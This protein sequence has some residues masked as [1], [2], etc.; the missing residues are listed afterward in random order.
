MELIPT[1]IILKKGAK[2]KLS[3]NF[4]QH[5]IDCK[6][7]NKLCNYTPINLKLIEALE[8]LRVSCGNRPLTITSGYRCQW[9]NSAP[10]ILGTKTSKHLIGNAV[11]LIPPRSMP[12][13]E[14]AFRARAFFDK[15]LIYTD[16]NF[17]HCHI[18]P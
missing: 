11:D 16:K 1:H 10:D 18:E 13:S 3:A 14:F 9:Y 8:A 6:C 4:N 12:L 17:I 15:V 5:E 2:T 7:G